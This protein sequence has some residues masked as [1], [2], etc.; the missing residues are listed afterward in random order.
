MHG[1]S[2]DKYNLLIFPVKIIKEKNPGNKESWIIAKKI[3]DPGES[4]IRRGGDGNHG[5]PV[6]ENSEKT[7]EGEKN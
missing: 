2:V 7:K 4:K 3:S 5:I 6:H 1:L